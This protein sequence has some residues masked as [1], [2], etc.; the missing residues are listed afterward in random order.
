MSIKQLSV[1]IENKTGAISDVAN[2]L[3]E[4]NIDLR[5]MCLADAKDY[6]VLRIISKE[7]ERAEKI[8]AENGHTAKATRVVAFKVPDEVGGLAGALNILNDAGIDIA[9]MY[10]LVTKEGGKAYIVVRVNDNE[11]AEQIL[12]EHGMKVL[13]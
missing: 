6:G 10:S 3:A 2:L 5:A 4:N 12:L 1:Y 8:L 7:I 11:K 13:K 9:Y